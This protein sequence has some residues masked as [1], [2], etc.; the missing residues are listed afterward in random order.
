[1]KKTITE[2]ITLATSNL[3]NGSDEAVWRLVVK[4]IEWLLITREFVDGPFLDRR[5]SVP[6]LKLKEKR[7]NTFYAEFDAAFGEMKK[8][9]N[10]RDLRAIFV[11]TGASVVNPRETWI[12]NL[13]PKKFG[14]T[15]C[16]II[17]PNVSSLL[18]QAQ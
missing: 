15:D 3:A 8:L 2:H 17:K 13:P 5:K 7:K 1:M 6:G 14:I 16:S 9:L 4:T 18:L 10:R 11:M 12:L